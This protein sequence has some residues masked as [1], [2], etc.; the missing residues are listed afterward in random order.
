[1]THGQ[2][3]QLNDVG[4]RIL[5]TGERARALDLSHVE[6]RLAAG[7]T[8]TVNWSYSIPAAPAPPASSRPPGL[9]DFCSCGLLP[10]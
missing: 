7:L 9:A 6:R 1:M 8:A 10:F 3:V 2:H 5:P 4:D